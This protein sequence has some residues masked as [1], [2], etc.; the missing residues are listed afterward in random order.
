MTHS[1]H[2]WVFYAADPLAPSV[3]SAFVRNSPTLYTYQ[4]FSDDNKTLLDHPGE[5]YATVEPDD[6]DDVV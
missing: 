5:N 2:V 4:S 1:I 6:S 3:F